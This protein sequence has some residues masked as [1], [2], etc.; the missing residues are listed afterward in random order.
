MFN[1]LMTSVIISETKLRPNDGSIRR[2]YVTSSLGHFQF[3]MLTR[4]KRSASINSYKPTPLYRAF[5]SPHPIH[6]TN[7]ILF[8]RTRAI[9]V[10]CFRKVRGNLRG[11][12]CPKA[13][14]VA[15]HVSLHPFLS[16][17]CFAFRLNSLPL[18]YPAKLYNFVFLGK[19]LWNATNPF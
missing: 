5:S 4:E 15:R 19:H 16:F 2:S 9:L 6:A 1:K 3:F 13:P 14:Y 11:G 8:S 10:E 12:T 7:T 17:T 18:H